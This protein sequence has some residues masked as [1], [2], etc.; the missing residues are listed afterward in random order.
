MKSARLASSW[1]LTLHTAS[2]DRQGAPVAGRVA[3][4]ARRIASG[5]SGAWTRETDLA[6][7]IEC[8]EK[9]P[10]QL[11]DKTP[12]RAYDVDAESACLHEFVQAFP[13]ARQSD[14]IGSRPIWLFRGSDV[15]DLSVEWGDADARRK[16]DFGVGRVDLHLFRAGAAILAVELSLRSRATSLADMQDVHDIRRRA[17]HPCTQRKRQR[18]HAPTM[19][20]APRRPAVGGVEKPVRTT[21]CGWWS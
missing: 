21:N 13:F 11:S 8:P 2:P 5:K 10:G 18:T 4:C 15:R 9:S 19:R 16:V 3:L 14:D 20:R 17:D 6:R 1:P 7:H 12:D